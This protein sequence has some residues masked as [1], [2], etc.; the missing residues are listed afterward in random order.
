[1]KKLLL[2]LGVAV[3]LFSCKKSASTASP[4]ALVSSVVYYNPS[5]Q[6]SVTFN[7]KYNSSQ[8]IT[9]LSYYSYDTS[10]GTPYL[11]SG[12]YYFTVNAAT[13]LPSAYMINSRKTGYTSNDIE[14]HD[15]FYDGQGRVIK[16]TMISGQANPG[17]SVANY[18]SYPSNRILVR[19]YSMY[20]YDPVN[21]YGWGASAVDTIN[22]SNGN[23]INQNEY[24]QDGTGW[25]PQY[26]YI[27][28]SY[29]NY[30]NPFNNPHF[31]NSLG[32]LLRDQNSIDCVSKDLPSDG[33]LHWTTDSGGKVVSGL[34]VDG[35]ITTF[36]YL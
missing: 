17:D 8:Q 15:L 16:D 12:T 21:G 24:E 2:I 9:Q 3:I 25:D 29:S 32:P 7:L 19:D 14:T 11:D 34:S 22:L 27:V 5:T 4:S 35:T 10:G 13:N 30:A 26:S 36:T 23:I 33:V 18:F 1:M 6:N 20:A 28:N 31:S